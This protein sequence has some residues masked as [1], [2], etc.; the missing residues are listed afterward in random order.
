MSSCS[1]CTDFPAAGTWPISGRLM[2]PASSTCTVRDRSGT[3]KTETSMMSEME[4]G[5]AT[6]FAAAG[7]CGRSATTRSVAS[8]APGARFAMPE[9]EPPSPGVM[10]LLVEQPAR[11]ARPQARTPAIRTWDLNNS[12]I[13]YPPDK[14]AKSYRFRARLSSNRSSTPTVT[15]SDFHNLVLQNLRGLA[16]D[17]RVGKLRPITFGEKLAGLRETRHASMIAM[18]IA[19]EDVNPALIQHAERQCLRTRTKPSQDGGSG[20]LHQAACAV[21]PVND[22]VM[23]RCPAKALRMRQHRHI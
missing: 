16:D 13:F 22:S 7:G 10:T 1:A 4:T 9:E 3:W 21:D 6:P 5:C 20:D 18:R 23:R 8:P 2:L 15:N 19:G 11:T 17:Q 12:R 14:A